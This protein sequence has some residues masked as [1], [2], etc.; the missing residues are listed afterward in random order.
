MEYPEHEKLQKVQKESQTCGE[1]FNFLQSKYD[2]CIFD[3][4]E[5]GEVGYRRVFV[6]VHNELG[7][8]FGIDIDELEK[9]KQHMLET[10]RN[11][12]A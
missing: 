2:F 10:L 8:F 5:D 4:D 7:E 12:N 9:E 6:D 1:F 3:E 11:A